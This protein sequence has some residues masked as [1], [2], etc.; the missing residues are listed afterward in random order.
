MTFSIRQKTGKSPQELV[1]SFLAKLRKMDLFINRYE[2]VLFPKDFYTTSFNSLL[3]EITESIQEFDGINIVIP[4]PSDAPREIPRI[5]LRSKNNILTCN[6]SMDRVN[7]A[8][9]N[10]HDDVKFEQS[11]S[12]IKIIVEKL[13][14]ILLSYTK[15]KTVK[16]VGYIK[17]LYYPADR[18]ISVITNST[19]HKKVVKDLKTFLLRFSYEKKLKS[20]PNC[21]E[22]V[23]V[24]D[25][26]TGKDKRKVIL[27]TADIN[28]HQDDDVEWETDKVLDFIEEANTEIRNKDLINR[29]IKK[30]ES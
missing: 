11:I 18:A 23:I 14:N 13:S 17:E 3:T 21:N 5:L 8:W 28:T 29:F 22:I 20:W 25:A 12:N 2:I 19:L 24:S 26:T 9:L 6:L 7:I 4:T 15:T 1:L 27:V 16:R 30:D 10:S